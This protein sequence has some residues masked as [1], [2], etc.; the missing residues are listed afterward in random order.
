MTIG[1]DKIF[2]FYKIL[3]YN[4]FIY[5]EE[6]MQNNL[7]IGERIRKIKSTFRFKKRI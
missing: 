3:Y 7:E 6:I 4:K 5:L 2:D 1:K